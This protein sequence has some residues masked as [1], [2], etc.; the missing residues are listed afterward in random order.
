MS[1]LVPSWENLAK[2]FITW[3][4]VLLKHQLSCVINGGAITQYF[5][6][7]KGARQGSPISAYLFILT[8]E[9]L[10]LHIKKIPK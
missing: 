6:L 1:F 3:I 5:N 10:F 7:E 8:L 9:I 2:N 4:E